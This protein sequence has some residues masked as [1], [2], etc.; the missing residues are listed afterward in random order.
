METVVNKTVVVQQPAPVMMAPPVIA[1]PSMGEMIV[2]NVVGN[3]VGNAISNTIM[4]RGPSGTD[5]MI[6]NQQRQ[7]ERQMDKQ[8]ME[9][10]SLKREMQDMKIAAVAKS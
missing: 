8:A 9:L 2:G 4:P 7:D 5:R 3:V 10:E 6:E 1:G